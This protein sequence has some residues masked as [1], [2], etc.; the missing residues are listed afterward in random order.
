VAWDWAQSLDAHAG[1]AKHVNTPCSVVAAV[2]TA[3]PAAFTLGVLVS[4]GGHL[5]LGLAREPTTL[6]PAA[7]ASD[8]P[9]P[10]PTPTPAP[11]PTAPLTPAAGVASPRQAVTD[12][13]T[14]EANRAFAASYALLSAADREEY[15]SG[16][17]GGSRAAPRSQASS[18]S[19]HWRGTGPARP[20]PAVVRLRSGLDPVLGLVPARV[21][22]DWS[23]PRRRGAGGSAS[24]IAATS[25][26]TR[27]TSRRPRRPSTPSTTARG[28]SLANG[29][30][31]STS[32]S[33][34]SSTLAACGR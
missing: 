27:P 10:A 5:D 19:P 23:R 33:A 7:V 6:P 15:P 2:W 11:S 28:C 1:V 8:P 4:G 26:S 22:I 20:V 29:T 17:G 14:A 13:L 24:A 25:P 18:W 21:R 34:R 9:T 31:S 32:T 16:L 12:F 30:T 3:V